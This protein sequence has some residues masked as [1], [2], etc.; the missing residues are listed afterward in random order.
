MNVKSDPFLSPP[1][2]DCPECRTKGG[3]G[4]LMVNRRSYVLRCYHCRTKE[5]IPLPPVG[6]RLIYLDQLAL[7]NLTKAQGQASP[8]SDE[9]RF[10]RAALERLSRLVRLQLLSCPVPRFT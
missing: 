1:Y 4:V 7:S 10:W 8:K 9:E 6:R 5:A 2:R 3:F